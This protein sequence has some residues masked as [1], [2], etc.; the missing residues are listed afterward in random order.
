MYRISELASK[1]G[2]SRTAL[3]YY[4]KLNLI[5]GQRLENGYRVYSDFDLQ[6]IKLI[7]QLHQGGLTLKECQACLDDKLDGALIKSRLRQLDEEI[8]QKRQSRNLL[9][10]I[11]GEG[12]E[13]SW[14][15][16]AIK[17]APDAHFDWL[18]T[19]GLDEKDALRLKWLSKNMT[20]HD[21]YMNDFMKVYEPLE[22]W[23]PGS[24]QDTLNALS[25]LPHSPTDVLE[26]GSGKGLATLVLAKSL[27]AN[28]TAIDNEQSALDSLSTLLANKGLASKVTTKCESM[29]A[30]TCDKN[31]FDLIWSEG[32]AYI[33]GVESALT[34]WKNY[35]HDEGYLVFSD[36]VYTT[37]SPN[38]AAK[39]FW[40]NE[41][42]DMQTVETR[43]QQI[44][45][46]GFDIVN[47][48]ALS[49]QAWNN[50][51]LPLKARVEQ[52]MPTMV[53]SKA[54]QDIQKEIELCLNFHQEFGYQMFI[55]KKK[56]K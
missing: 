32:A 17:Q 54:L 55:L 14:H 34:S 1:V 9:A 19:Q 21:Q 4:E 37:T 2:L 12:D 39:A 18:K 46:C 35:L 16:A 15:Q 20:Q 41:Y 31:A 56:A 10:A 28:I 26:I 8:K 44:V 48:F 52:L 5:Q 27:A 47:D 6:R 38:K 25:M 45:A 49:R 11:V 36:L 23:G 43:R 51:Y 50:Y 40:E 29:T 53:G 24:E 33:M 3:L 7:Q 42:P 13:T 30:L 22:Y